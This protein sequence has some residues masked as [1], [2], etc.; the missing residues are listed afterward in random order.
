[1]TLLSDI[2][3][4]GYGLLT[5]TSYSRV[6]LKRRCKYYLGFNDVCVCERKLLS[7][8][9]LPGVRSHDIFVLKIKSLYKIIVSV[10]IFNL[11]Q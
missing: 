1:M 6:K 4:K 7:L 3:F 9:V 8:L 2:C 10:L 11:T 5:L